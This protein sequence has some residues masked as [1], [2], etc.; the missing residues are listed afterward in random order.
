MLKPRV[1][2]TRYCTLEIGFK[3]FRHLKETRAIRTSILFILCL[4]PLATFSQLTIHDLKGITITPKPN[5]AFKEYYEALIE[6]PLDHFNLTGKSFRQRIYVGINNTKAPTVM[7]TEGYAIGNASLPPFMKG[8]NYISVE[9]RYFGKSVPDSL[10]WAYLTIRQAASDLHHIRALFGQVL[11][12][13]W[14]TTGISKGGQTAIAYKMYFPNDAD[15][16]LAYV[17]PI[18][19]SIADNRLTDYL[20]STLTTECGKKIF[21][22]QKFAFK[23]KAALLADFY[24]YTQDQKLVFTHIKAEKVFEYLLL[25]YPFAFYQNCFDC[26]LIPDTTA[27]TAEIVAEIVSVVSPRY[28]SD[29]FRSKLEPSFYMFYHEL[30]YYEYNLGPYRQ[31][32]SSD[33]YK[34]D[35]FAPQ[36]TALSFDTTYLASLNRF[37]SNP[38]TEKIIFVY[39]ELDPYTA[40]RPAL[41][42]NQNCFTVIAKNGCHKS[43]VADLTAAQQQAIF[44]QLSTWLDWAVGT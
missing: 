42:D 35:I 3:T 19:N 36:N 41:G 24:K 13:K 1:I 6:Q 44:Q 7:E 26:K 15:A 33:S 11:K 23:T 30:G 5:S 43:R 21:A 40:A 32:L 29:A 34:N 31:W 28:Y 17:T 8:C 27:T 12:G 18:K 22:F 25:E 9:H 14:M 37:I 2:L 16:T 39:G 38:S 10:N 20:Q 4:F